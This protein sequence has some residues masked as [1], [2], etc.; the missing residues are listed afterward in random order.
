MA[1][2]M[3][4]NPTHQKFDWYHWA[5]LG[6]AL[7]SFLMTALVSGRV[8]ERLP[9]L[10]DEVAYLFQAKIFARM[11]LVV[12]TPEPSR[13]YWQPFVVDDPTTGNRMGKYSPGWPA[14]LAV[15]VMLGTPWV[16]NGFLAMLTVGLTY[17]LGRE[18]FNPDVG[19]IAAALTAFS[20]MALLLNGSLMGHTAALTCATL[21][22]WAYWRMERAL[23]S[24]NRAFIAIIRWGIVAG[25]ALG[26][27]AIN[28]P[29][30]AVAAALP[31]VMWSV[32]RLARVAIG[33]LQAGSAG[34][35]AGEENPADDLA[36]RSSTVQLNRRA[37]FLR[38]LAPLVGLGVS[39]VIICGAIPVFNVA[40]AGDPTVNLYTYVWPY[41][42]IGFGEGYGR[43]GHTLEKAFRHTRFDLS[44]TAADLFG[45]QLGEVTPSVQQHLRTNDAYFPNTGVSW[46]LLPFGLLIGLWARLRNLERKQ[47]PRWWG[48]RTFLLLVWCAVSAVLLVSSVNLPAETLQSRD[49]ALWW[50]S[51]AGVWLFVPFV[52]LAIGR[53]DHQA[54]WTWLFAAVI[55]SVI[56]AQFTYWIGSQR[57]STRYYFEALTAAALLS[58][59]PLAWLARLLARWGKKAW[60]RLPI[61]ALLG[62]LLLHSLYNYSTPRIGAL[63]RFNFI[64]PD[65][66]EAVEAQQVDDRPVLV[67][68]TGA[69][70]RWRAHGPL[71]AVTSPFLDSEIVVAHDN[72]Q[73]GRRDAILARFPDR[74]VIE[75]TATGNT[76]CFTDSPTRCFGEVPAT[77]QGG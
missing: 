17:R 38:T 18:V 70:V 12:E 15:G 24:P 39:A 33:G 27:L 49:F 71:M 20:P 52:L 43:N 67:L 61:Y 40:A 73:A 46:L 68:V 36:R 48:W 55:L 25:I 77:A 51:W 8:F 66:I 35:S 5:A 42:R 63:Y 1:R 29:L 45:W 53:Q 75:M 19:L 62:I 6:L 37:Q 54:N 11:Q 58:A 47:L 13:A 2:M 50:L 7:F 74:Q 59:I 3:T 4:D 22:M 23:H 21:F 41:D 9:H 57:Y 69:D 65:L 72:L 32:A 64:T 16:I 44:L 34:L 76:I 14:F 28:R 31:F 60:L 26:L 30:S 10:E 56:Y